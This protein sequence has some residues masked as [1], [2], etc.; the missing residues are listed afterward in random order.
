MLECGGSFFLKTKFNKGR[1]RPDIQTITLVLITIF[2]G[3]DTTFRFVNLWLKH[4][5]TLP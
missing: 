1:F 2:D 5:T 3:E 4:G